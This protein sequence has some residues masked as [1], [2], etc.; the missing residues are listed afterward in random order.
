MRVSM[1]I[2]KAEGPA[3]GGNQFANCLESRLAANGH[4]VFRELVRRLDLILIVSNRFHAGTTAYDFDAIAEYKELHPNTVVVHR[5]NDS[6][7]AKGNNLGINAKMAEASRLAD[8]S[9]FVSGHLRELH[10]RHGLDAKKPGCVILNGSDEAVFNGEGRA[11]WA[12][13]GKLRI[14]T[15]HWSSNFLKGYDVYERLDQLLGVPPYR[16]YF[17][18]TCIGNLPLGVEFRN[19]RVMRHL[20][21]I[22][23]ARE[24][25]SHHL[26]VTA[27]RNEPGGQHPVEAM[28]CGLPV[29]YLES[30]SLPEYCG[31]YGIAFTLAN[32][33]ARLL[34]MRE[35]YAEL[36]DKALQCPYS[37]RQMAQQYEKIFL[38]LVE[39][40][41]AQPR[42]PPGAG[43]RLRHA[44]RTLRRHLGV[45]RRAVAKRI[46][47]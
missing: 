20:S 30:G 44:A 7:E 25:K 36:R 8:F 9:I 12:P 22:E 2:E 38:E 33:E 13:G 43:A 29:L 34:T 32:F 31:P 15:H 11:A 16:G 40:R 41:R 35:R 17:E 45:I 21:G 23:L 39:E 42:P 24:I 37:G 3:G 47:G 28:Q 19:T 6:D 46:G 4:E 14:V 10:L 5:V 26:Y 1:N 27:A 18:F